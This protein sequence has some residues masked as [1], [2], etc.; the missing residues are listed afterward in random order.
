[1]TISI[2][3]M[4]ARC[5]EKV[6]GF[7][8][9]PNSNVEIP[10]TIIN[11]AGEGKTVLMTS[12]IHGGE[13][14]GIQTA[15]ELSDEL[16]PKDVCGAVVI[17]HPVNTQAFRAKLPAVVPEDGKN[18]NREFPG[19]EDGTITQR[20]AWYI[21]KDFHDIADFYVDMH[22][23][24]LHELVMPYVYFPGIGDQ[25][26][27]EYSRSAAC[28]L[29][30][31]YMVRSNA[32]TGAYNSAAIRGV[33]SLLIERGGNGLWSKDEV[34]SYKADI[35]NLLRFLD[36]LP[37][38]PWLPRTQPI[39]INKAIYL[40]SDAGGC[41]YPDVQPSQKISKGQKL[42]EIRDFFGETIKV[43][44]SPVDGVVLYMTTTLAIGEGSSIVAIGEL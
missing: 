14:P 13:Y 35:V 40:N 39:E 34:R 44:T 31:P 43:Y 19:K 15:I 18:L 9:I 2:G 33:P 20:T 7:Y 17:V 38:K 4:A 32:T 5:G 36:V 27:V 29:D 11:G 10:V 23:G 21:T 1:M 37:G 6:K 30:L 26:V 25:E 42:G 12:G 22:G 3:H 28:M 8:T 41:W 16:D 24:D